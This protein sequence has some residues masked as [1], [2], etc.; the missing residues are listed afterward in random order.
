MSVVLIAVRHDPSLAR[1]VAICFTNLSIVAE[2][3]GSRAHNGT[4]E[5]LMEM[6]SHLTRTS[7]PRVPAPP[8]T[9]TFAVHKPYRARLPPPRERARQHLRG[10]IVHR[11]R[12]V[13]LVSPGDLPSRARSIRDAHAASRSGAASAGHAGAVDLPPSNRPILGI[14]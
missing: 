2:T 10:L 1:R 7:H 8:D 9:R 6:L 13:S 3:N 5:W 11:L 14:C 4:A 12:R